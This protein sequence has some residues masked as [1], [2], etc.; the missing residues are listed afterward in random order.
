MVLCS[1]QLY[2]VALRAIHPVDALVIV[3]EV[4]ATVH[5]AMVV[6]RVIHPVEAA[7]HAQPIQQREPM[8]SP[9]L[10]LILAVI[11]VPL[12]IL[13]FIITI[14]LMAVTAL[15]SVEASLAEYWAAIWEVP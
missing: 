9:V 8:S 10:I 6:N 1:P 2:P 5:Q 13:L 4:E 3:V 14:I 11:L 12:A 15:A 7:I